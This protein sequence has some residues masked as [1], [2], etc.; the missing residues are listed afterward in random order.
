MFRLGAV[1]HRTRRAEL[2]SGSRGGWKSLIFHRAKSPETDFQ[3]RLDWGVD[4]VRVLEGDH[5]D[6][7]SPKSIGR[8][9]R[10]L[11]KVLPFYA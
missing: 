10:Y 4:F 9:T 5:A 1:R 3:R 2:L 11:A 6:T 7:P 8:R